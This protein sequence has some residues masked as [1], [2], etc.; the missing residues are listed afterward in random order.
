MDRD[1]FVWRECY[2][3]IEQEGVLVMEKEGVLGVGQQDMLE[4]D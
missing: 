3:L 1:W 2:D 4:I